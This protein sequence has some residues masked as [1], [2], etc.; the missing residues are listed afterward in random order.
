M[1]PTAR[2]LLAALA[3]ALA[4]SLAHAQ[5]GKYPEKPITFIVPFAA[6]SATDQLARALGQSITEQT[7]Q[8]VIVDNKAGA[9][10]MLARAPERCRCRTLIEEGDP[11]QHRAGDQ[12]DDA[13]LRAD[14]KHGREIERRQRRVEQQQ[15]DRA[16]KEIAH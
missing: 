16:G 11:R 13:E 4:A 14:E 9:S 1:T 12:R 6:G 10:G 8:A 2:R 3:A 15:H 5:A 7:K